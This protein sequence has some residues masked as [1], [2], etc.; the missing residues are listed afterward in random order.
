MTRRTTSASVK[1]S[2]AVAG[3]VLAVFIGHALHTI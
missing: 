2:P 3:L 1:G